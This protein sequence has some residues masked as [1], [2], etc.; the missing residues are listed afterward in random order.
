MDLFPNLFNQIYYLLKYKF[1]L[2]CRLCLQILAQTIYLEF[3]STCFNSCKY[4][5]W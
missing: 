5:Y 2:F 3:T 1:L 4:S